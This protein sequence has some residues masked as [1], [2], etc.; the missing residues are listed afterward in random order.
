MALPQRIL[1]P[2]EEICMDWQQRQR[3]GAGLCNLGSTCYINVIL[4][5]LTYTPPLANYLL[6]RD[7]SQLCHRQG[8]CMMCI[9]EAHVRKVL[10]SSANVIWPRAVV[11]DLK[12]IGEEFEPDMAG[13]AYEFLR[14]ALEAMQRAC[15]SG[16]SGV[17]ISSQTTT[18]IHQIFG[19]FLK[20]RVICLRCQAVSDSYKAFLH[21]LLDIKAPSSLTT[22]LEDFVTP[23]KLDGKYCFKCSKCEKRVTAS[24]RV[25]VHCVPKV[26]TVCLERAADHTGK[27][28][29]KI[30][31][32]PEYLDLRPYMS[33]TAGEPLLYSLYALVVHSGDTCLDGHFFCYT[34]ASNGLWYKMDDE[35]VDNCGIHTVLR[36]QAYLLFYARCSDLKMGGMVASSLTPSYAHPFLSQWQASS[37]QAG[38]AGTHDPPGRT[39]SMNCQRTSARKRIQSRSLQ[40][41]NDHCS[42]F[43]NSSSS[44]NSTGRKRKRTSPPGRDHALKDSTASGPFNRS[45]WQAPAPSA[46]WV[47]HLPRQ[48]EQSQSSQQGYDLCRRFVETTDYHQS[49]RR[50]SWWKRSPPHCDQNLKNDPPEGSLNASSK[51]ASAPCA[52]QEQC[53]PRQ[54]EQSRS[55]W[56]YDLRR[57]FVEITDY[58]Q[59]A[60]RRRKHSFGTSKQKRQS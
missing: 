33:D 12:F 30:V 53:L 18:I 42:W 11:R 60:K 58:H 59:S 38:S 19:G 52:A 22:A 7:H 57:R 14:C 4:Q 43:M 21:V 56:G 31:E 15:L 37:E 39:M 24:K 5:C 48:R 44:N 50:R 20:S 32:Y 1:F 49:V 8:F 16:S 41:G 51:R 55:Q 35:S 46:T 26:F 47:Q 27:K 9:M 17:D 2:P 40:W 29:S 25:T 13:D 23:K 45:C 28:I 36:Q 3:P 10:R 54:R 34:K 6:S